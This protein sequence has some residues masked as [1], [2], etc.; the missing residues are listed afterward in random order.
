M[1]LRFGIYLGFVIWL[2]VFTLG[3]SRFATPLVVYGDQMVVEV[4]MRGT[5]DVYNNRYFMVLSTSSAYSVPLPPPDN[6][7][8]E[9]IEPGDTPI[10]G[11]EEAYYTNYFSSWASYII[12]EPA[13]Y[14]LANG[15]FVYN[16]TATREQIAPLG[17]VTNK[18][19]FTYDLSEIFTT[20]PDNIYFDIISVEWPTGQVKYAAD[21]FASTNNYISKIQ[22]SILNV[23][24]SQDASLA[25][26]LDIVSC[27]VEIQ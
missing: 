12:L 18:I 13:G 23:T 6:I 8:Y 26:D 21:H 19:S 1:K 22:G 3:C 15:P 20:I 14:Y 9:F 4:T 7:S 10:L 17:S 5:L 11:T 2:L 24:D 27:R 25:V 16:Q